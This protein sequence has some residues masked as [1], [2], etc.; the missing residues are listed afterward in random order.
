MFG[1]IKSSLLIKVTYDFLVLNHLRLCRGHFDRRKSMG[2]NNTNLDLAREK[3]G[4]DL[5]WTSREHGWFMYAE[6]H[7]RLGSTPYQA[8][9]PHSIGEECPC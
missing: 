9:T 4:K 3:R 6:L 2:S 7:A 8:F 5:I 1:V